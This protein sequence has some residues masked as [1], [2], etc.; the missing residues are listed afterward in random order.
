MI[1]FKVFN[2]FD[3]VK[4]E[5]SYLEERLKKFNQRGAKGRTMKYE[6]CKIIKDEKTN[7]YVTIAWTDVL[8]YAKMI[9]ADLNALEDNKYVVLKN[10]NVIA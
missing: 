6:I 8:E 7:T 2:E 10:G 9:V 3:N 5:I 4:E 1:F